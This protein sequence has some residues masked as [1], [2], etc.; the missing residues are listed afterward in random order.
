MADFTGKIKT[1]STKDVG[2]KKEHTV[3]S[4]RKDISSLMKIANKI[5]FETGG[6]DLLGVDSAYMLPD[7]KVNSKGGISA[8]F[9]FTHRGSTQL[10]SMYN[11]LARY[12][13]S[14]TESTRA[15][16][17]EL[18]NQNKALQGLN[19][20]RDPE[21]DEF[22]LSDLYDLIELKD[23]MPELFDDATY[24]DEMVKGL[25]KNESGSSM[26]NIAYQE[27]KKLQ[28]SNQPFTS[29]QLKKNIIKAIEK[30]TYNPS[31]KKNRKGMRQ[32]RN[33]VKKG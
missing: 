21:Y 20:I 15:K 16:K 30:G 19:K 8:K 17:I 3:S 24:Y 26:L 25:S 1:I 23:S 22:G 28:S 31:K 33:A 5:R 32:H 27:K 29:K 14:D 6:T 2:R 9:D 12:I 7:F 4:L 13:N 18:E 10:V 11:Q